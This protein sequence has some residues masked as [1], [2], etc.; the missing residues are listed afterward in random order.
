MIRNQSNQIDHIVISGRA[1]SDDEAPA[2]VTLTSNVT[3]VAP[4]S[5]SPVPLTGS[6][7]HSLPFTQNAGLAR[8]LRITAAP[9]LPTDFKAATTMSQAD[10]MVVIATG[11]GQTSG[12]YWYSTRT[13]SSRP[14]G[15][16]CNGSLWL[17]RIPEISP[18]SV[19][20]IRKGAGSTLGQWTPPGQ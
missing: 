20:M 11:A 17:S 4:A 12:T 16:W 14:N 6:L 10:Q 3:I 18:A 5:T 2:P 9:T 15:G 8:G 19:I 1:F 13:T 7:G